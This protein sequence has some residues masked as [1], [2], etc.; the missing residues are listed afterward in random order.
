[1]DL[2]PG[3][4][5]VH[6]VSIRLAV[7]GMSWPSVTQFKLFENNRLNYNLLSS[8]SCVN[9]QIWTQNP[10][11]ARSCGFES[12]LRHHINICSIKVYALKGVS[13]LFLPA[14]LSQSF[15]TTRSHNVVTKRG[16][17]AIRFS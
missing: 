5:S 17:M 3:R 13:L 15:V 7:A 12:H 1:M 6:I 4:E 2:V 16:E 11:A 9:C 8:R 10:V 14:L